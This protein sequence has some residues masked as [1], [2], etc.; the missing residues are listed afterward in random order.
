MFNLCKTVKIYQTI[1]HYHIGDSGV[2]HLVDSHEL[3]YQES[4]APS[5]NDNQEDPRLQTVDSH[6]TAPRRTG[7]S[8]SIREAQQNYPSPAK[9]MSLTKSKKDSLHASRTNSSAADS[10]K[11]RSSRREDCDSPRIVESK[12]TWAEMSPRPKACDPLPELK[13][14]PA[15]EEMPILAFLPLKKETTRTTHASLPMESQRGSDPKIDAEFSPLKRSSFLRSSGRS[16]VEE[17]MRNSLEYSL[18]NTLDLKLS[19]SRLRKEDASDS[20]LR[21]SCSSYSQ[22]P[23]GPQYGY[24]DF[25]QSCSLELKKEESFLKEY[26]NDVSQSIILR[27]GEK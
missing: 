24:S 9:G 18:R 6:S 16:K 10:L 14:T 15:E 12:I 19:G 22:V 8:V 23:V 5:K 17:S 27:P 26:A 2:G 11:L 3:K 1:N 4:L 25:S 20:L 13:P 21:L 7:I